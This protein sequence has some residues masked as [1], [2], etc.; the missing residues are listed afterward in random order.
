MSSYC[1]K[2]FLNP[3]VE[4]VMVD[5]NVHHYT[6]K[7]TTTQKAATV[8]RMIKTLKNKIYRYLTLNNSWRYIDVLNKLVDSINNT[9]CR[10][11]SIAPNE[12]NDPKTIEIVRKK[13]YPKGFLPVERLDFRFD[14]GQKVRLARKIQAFNKGYDW[15]FL[16]EIFT[17]LK[18]IHGKG[19][20][21][22]LIADE[23]GA[24]IMGSFHN[25]QLTL[26]RSNMHK[27]PQESQ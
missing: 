22:Y 27:R 10:I 21:R 24:E 6:V 26:V 1:F 17:I 3:A 2:E 19:A 25:E 9:P 5:F 15:T 20:A 13:L 7:L 23:K 18:R 4:K 14:V 16:P 11:T 12:V 8:E